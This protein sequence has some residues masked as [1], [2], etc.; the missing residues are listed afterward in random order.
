ME[1]P[2]DTL[3]LRSLAKIGR[4]SKNNDTAA[5]LAL[6]RCINKQKSGRT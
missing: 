3:C 1:I 4:V 2:Y 6:H 5:L